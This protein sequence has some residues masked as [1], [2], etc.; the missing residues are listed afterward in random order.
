MYPPTRAARGRET[1]AER[2]RGRGG[3]W[4]MP[5]TTRCSPPPTAPIL[6]GRLEEDDEDDGDTVALLLLGRPRAESAAVGAARTET[7]IA[8]ALSVTFPFR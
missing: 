1:T 7:F 2:C 6:M 4:G 3:N 8:T 5:T